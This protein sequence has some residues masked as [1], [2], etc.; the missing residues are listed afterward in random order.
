MMP[1]GRQAA[2]QRAVGQPQSNVPVRQA[3]YPTGIGNA[4]APWQKAAV[5]QTPTVDTDRTAAQ[6]DDDA[7]RQE[8]EQVK[9]QNREYKREKNQLDREKIDKKRQKLEQ[10]RAKLNQ[11]APA[12][13]TPMRMPNRMPF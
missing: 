10:D 8:R 5:G 4:K 11:P 12:G 13:A 1:G 6:A 7:I 2:L 3:K 9:Q